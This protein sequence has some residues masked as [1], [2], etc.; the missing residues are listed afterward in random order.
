MS[1]NRAVS[2]ERTTAMNMASSA[3]SG[4]ASVMVMNPSTGTRGS[5]EPTTWRRNSD[6]SS[7]RVDGPVNVLR[8]RWRDSHRR[9]QHRLR[10]AQHG[11]AIRQADVGPDLAPQ[12]EADPD[13]V[14]VLRVLEEIRLRIR[15]RADQPLR[16][17]R[18]AR[19][20]EQTNGNLYLGV[21]ELVNGVPVGVGQ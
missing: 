3:P 4:P 19:H 20:L 9:A 15:D 1:E 8:S 11:D 18:G 14:V 2:P 16:A 17:L 21:V 10:P 7:G 13:P 12:R 6:R 5:P